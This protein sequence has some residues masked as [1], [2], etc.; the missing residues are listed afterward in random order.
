V[1][2]NLA[3]A[4]DLIVGFVTS[5][6]K[7][8]LIR[9]VG[10]GLN[11]VFGLS[12]FYPDPMFT[13]YNSITGAIDQDDDWNSSLSPTF[14]SVGAFPLTPGSK[15]AA[16]TRTVSGSNTAVVNGA[17]SGLVLVEVY[18][19]ESAGSTSTRLLN[20]SARNQVG[21]GA[22]VLISGFVLD[23]AVA[24]TVL[25]RG[26]GPALHDVFGVN[27]QLADPV[28]EIHQTVNGVDTVVASNDNWDSS[29]IP[30]FDQ[31]GAYHF[32]AGSKDAALL[33]TLSPGVYTAQVSGVNS[34]TGDGV[35]EVYVVDP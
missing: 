1:R 11:T 15:D 18:D 21:T 34:G 22:N 7:S 9:A 32:S 17:G 4:Q 16:L 19:A 2:T 33:V 23:G 8:L 10:P 6:P 25:I 24:R 14:A 3:A 29:L 12:G 31:V 13:L 28:L 30:V 5:G 26:V 27:G 20:V 35:V